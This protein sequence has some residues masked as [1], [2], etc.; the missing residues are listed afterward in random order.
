LYTQTRGG[1]VLCLVLST[2]KLIWEKDL[3]GDS[4]TQETSWGCCSSPVIEGDIVLV[5]AGESGIALNRHTGKVRWA[6]G[7]AESG[8]STPIV[9]D[10]AGRRL[11]AITGKTAFHIVDVKT[12]DVLTST[13]WDCDAD[14]TRLGHRF[15]LMGCHMKGKGSAM[16]VM[17]NGKLDVVWETK[18]TQHSFQPPI[19]L[20]GHAY[21]LSYKKRDSQPLQCIDLKNGRIKWT[22]EVGAW[23]SFSA[24]D[25]RLIILEGDGD[26]VIADASPRA[27]K[28]I[29]RTSLFSL[30]SFDDYPDGEPNCCWTA[31]VLVDGYLY[32]RSTHG[33]LACVNLNK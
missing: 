10:G 33:E 13:P 8:H 19:V 28:E 14:A 27:Y 24:A 31:P 25:R 23:G 3:V 2:G 16:L 6:S 29:A 30:K 26:L 22:Q 9:F 17:N 32:C 12:G 4:L 18:E 15:Y 1:A 11:A 20:D 7:F 5:N 21:V